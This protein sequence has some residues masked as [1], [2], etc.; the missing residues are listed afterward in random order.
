M[1][2]SWKYDEQHIY[3][4]IPGKSVDEFL[5]MDLR[6]GNDA[7]QT[8]RVVVTGVSQSLCALR[9]LAKTQDL[10][11]PFQS[12]DKGVSDGRFSAIT[13]VDE[14]EYDQEY[15]FNKTID[16][17]SFKSYMHAKKVGQDR[18]RKPKKAAS[19]KVTADAHNAV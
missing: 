18:V 6:Q 8:Y 14:P 17:E 1:V 15:Y 4:I 9:K 16:R 7:A 5:T 3:P 2:A 11:G 10:F 19:K 12:F 13:D